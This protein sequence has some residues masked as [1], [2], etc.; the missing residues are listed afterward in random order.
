[1]TTTISL[2]SAAPARL[3]VD[4]LVI[5]VLPAGQDGDG[6]R[7]AAGAEGVDEALDGRLAAALRAVGATGKAEEVT[8]L[9]TLGALPAP[10]IVAVGLGVSPDAEAGS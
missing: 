4:A 2:D 6:V 9:P 5:G 7:P 10:L 8:R 3:D 1:M